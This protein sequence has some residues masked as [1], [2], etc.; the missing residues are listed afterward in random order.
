MNGAGSSAARQVPARR[1]WLY[2]RRTRRD[3][4][5]HATCSPAMF[6]AT[7]LRQASIGVDRDYGNASTPFKSIID[8]R[9]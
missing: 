6:G 5:G 2:P 1:A 7:T 9:R 4:P 3:P 8:A